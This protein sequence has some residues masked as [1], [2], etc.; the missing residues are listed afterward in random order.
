MRFW[1]LAILMAAPGCGEL[2]ASA[3]RELGEAKTDYLDQ[4]YPAATNR[5]DRFLQAYPKHKDAAEGYYLR[6][7]C[8]VRMSEKPG[9]L[10]DV[11][12]CIRVSQDEA[13]RAKGHAMAASLLYETGRTR[14]AIEHFARA[15]GR[16][17]EQPPTDLARYR[18]GVCLQ[19]EGRWKEARLQFAAV[20]QRYPGSDL[21]PNA[22]QMHDWPH[23]HFSI[24]CGAFRDEA[25]AKR[26]AGDLK[27][28]GLRARVE[29]RP[30]RGERL[31]MVFAGRYP[32]FDQA[33]D[34][35]RRV[36]RHVQD[37]LIVP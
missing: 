2:P 31:Y 8:R 5:L 32:M 10:E 36:Q 14:A 1:L 12:Q 20:F 7:L 27:K 28:A 25:G 11:Q 15:V 33:R 4:D 13:L 9:A 30:R 37:A 18:Y 16:L 19:R 22:R 24:Q 17:P 6:A 34:A 3:W 29:T 35:V 23:D 26:V 21:A